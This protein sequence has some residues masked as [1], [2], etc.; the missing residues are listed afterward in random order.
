MIYSI[1]NFQYGEFYDTSS[2]LSGWLSLIATIFAIIAAYHIYHKQKTDNEKDANELF[3]NY[4]NFLKDAV[5]DTLI[6]LEEFKTSLSNPNDD[7][8][9]P[10]L[11]ASLND[12]LLGKIEISSLLRYYEKHNPEKLNLLKEFIKKSSFWGDYHNYFM[13]ELNYFRTYFLHKEEQFFK[14][15][16][17]YGTIFYQISLGSYPKHEPNFALEYSELKSK[18]G[19]DKSIIDNSGMKNRL[20]FNTEFISPLITLSF[21]YFQSDDKAIEVN[22]LANEVNAARNDIENLKTSM[23]T[24]IGKDIATFKEIQKLITKLHV[25]SLVA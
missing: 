22:T 3:L 6:K 2:S 10:V 14:Y 11:E 17:L 15:Q 24:V 16:L 20:K 5:N 23:I 18:I 25:P 4:L 12:K 13:N 8:T 21:K 19:S 7:F 9:N 1:F